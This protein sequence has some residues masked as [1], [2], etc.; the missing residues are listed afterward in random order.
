MNDDIICKNC[1][2]YKGNCGHHFVNADGHINYDIPS[3]TMGDKWGGGIPSC[4]EASA[5]YKKERDMETVKE[6]A[7]CYSADIL[8]RAL[9]YKT[10]SGY[11]SWLKELEKENENGQ[12]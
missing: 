1:A 9:K 5:E 6:L 12:S 7:R 8:K 2:H 3:E 11:L 4:W 10:E